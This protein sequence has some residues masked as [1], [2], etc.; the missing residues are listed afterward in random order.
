MVVHLYFGKKDK[1]LI[2]WKKA[3]PKMAFSS[4]IREIIRADKRGEILELPLEFE[5]VVDDEKIETKLYF[6]GK[7]EI[8]F[9]RAIPR[10]R[11]NKKIKEVLR[12]HLEANKKCSL[13]KQD[14]SLADEAEELQEEEIIPTDDD[15]SDE[16]RE[17]LRKMSGK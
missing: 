7:D 6:T 4:Y 13:Q 8:W 2:A 3:L 14:A 1:D 15:M 9:I 12:R 11:R 10:Y 17:M 16:Y 5:E